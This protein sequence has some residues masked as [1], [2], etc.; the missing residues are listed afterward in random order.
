[1]DNNEGTNG[2]AV[3]LVLNQ[4]GEDIAA[5]RIYTVRMTMA[6][7]GVTDDDNH[8]GR[9]SAQRIAEDIFS[10]E[11]STCMDKTHK[12]LDSDFKT[13][14]DLTQNQGQIRITPGVKN[15]I[16]AF[17]QWARDEYDLGVI[18]SMES[19]I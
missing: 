15:N 8:D 1:M 11:F 2:M 19:L 16:K 9:S 17:V 18:P 4:R 13:Y 7:C 10:N 5:P 6:E 14:Y 3:H 12:E